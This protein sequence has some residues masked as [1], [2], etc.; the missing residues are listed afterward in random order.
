VEQIRGAWAPGRRLRFDLRLAPPARHRLFGGDPP[1]CCIARTAP[2]HST[3]HGGPEDG[4]ALVMATSGTT[5]EPKGVVLTSRRRSR[6]G[7]C[8]GPA[9][10]RRLRSDAWW[11]CLLSRTSAASRSSRGPLWGACGVGGR[12]GFSRWRVRRGRSEAAPRSRPSCRPHFTASIRNS[13][14]ASA[15]SSL[16]GRRR[17][18]PVAHVRDRTADRD[19]ERSRLRGSSLDVPECRVV[20]G[21]IECAGPMLLRCTARRDPKDGAGGWRPVR[22]REDRARREVDRLYGRLTR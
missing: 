15:G 1:A 16:G 11:A 7:S 9:P 17:P 18:R 2:L 6:L 4:D 20:D 21:E 10:G 19:G 8:H 5:G 22:C 12:G 14:P 3:R 13:P